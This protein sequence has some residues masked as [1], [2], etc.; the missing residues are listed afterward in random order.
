ME[1][2]R[3]AAAARTTAQTVTAVNRA[4]SEGV[5]TAREKASRWAK[6]AIRPWLAQIDPYDGHAAQQFTEAAAGRLAIAQKTTAVTAAAGQ[7]QILTMMGISVTPRPS[8]PLDI[9]APGAIFDGGRVRLE[10]DNVSVT[11]AG[12][13]SAE[14]SAQDLT[15]VEVLNRPVRAIRYL[16]SQ[17]ATRDE[18]LRAATERLD[19]I[20][21]DNLMLSQRFA[22]SEVI[23]LAADQPRSRIVGMRRVIHPE[24]SRTGVCGLCIAAA[25]RIY[26]VRQLL[27]IHKRCKCTT[28]AVT[29]EFDPAA[30]L[31]AIDLSQLYTD[32]GGTSRAHLKR[33]RYQTDQHGELGAVLVPQRDYKPRGVEAEKRA[34]A[35]TYVGGPESKA[36]IARRHLPILEENLTKLRADGLAEESSQVR[37]HKAQIEKLRA[38]LAADTTRAKP[39]AQAIKGMNPKRK[40]P[41]PATSG[42]S[43]G[44]EP[45]RPPRHNGPISAD[46]D[47]PVARLNAIFAEQTR[48]ASPEQ[49]QSVIRWQGKSD[50]FYSEVQRAAQDQ[51]ANPTANEVADDLQDLM[52]PLAEDVDLWRGIRDAEAVFGVPDDQIESLIGTDMDVPVFFATTLDREVTEEFT[53]PG[54]RPALYKITAR[55]GTPAAWVSP[56]GRP[57]DAYQQELLFPPGIVVRILDVKRTSSVPIV[58]VEVRDGE[59]GR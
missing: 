22:E 29:E 31:N 51:A 4:V 55:A 50:R 36:D 41:K 6:A 35:V 39:A 3:A 45:P 10:H 47:D 38:D 23:N 57:E 32:A 14:L 58:E 1:A 52:I 59:V 21:D 2:A 43:G 56:L 30:E 37:Y 34:S 8:S 20:V 54:R 25:D 18:A 44:D 48:N 49:R 42:G 12:D 33:T 9:R 24:L 11:Y 17:G 26:T 40:A 28:A 7:K 27:P 19:V 5:I 13:E 16:E 53:S 46:G 15:T